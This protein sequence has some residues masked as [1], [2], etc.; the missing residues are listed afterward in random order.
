M[1]YL[2]YYE[3]TNNIKLQRVSFVLNDVLIRFDLVH[4]TNSLRDDIISTCQ[5]VD[6]T[7]P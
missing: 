7:G 6:E 3:W 4:V 5:R 1:R 2:T